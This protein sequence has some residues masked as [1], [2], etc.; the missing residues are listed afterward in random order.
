MK[1]AEGEDRSRTLSTWAGVTECPQ[2]NKLNKL[3]DTRHARSKA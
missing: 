3:T 1:L 2:F